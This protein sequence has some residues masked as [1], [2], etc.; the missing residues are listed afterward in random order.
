MT[1]SSDVRDHI[2]VSSV[3][4]ADQLDQIEASIRRY[5][6]L[7]HPD[8]AMLVAVWIA[9]TYTFECFDYC[10]YLHIQSDTWGCGKT[11]LL[12][13][14]RHHAKAQPP[15][16]TAPTA[17]VVFRTQRDVQV[18][19]LDEAERLR[20]HDKDN[21]GTLLQVLNAGVEKDG[22]VTR[23]TKNRIGG[24]D[25]TDFPLFGP[26][27]FAGLDD[28]AAALASRCFHVQMQAAAVRPERFRSRNVEQEARVIRDRLEQWATDQE[29]AL[30][31]V[32]D[33]MV[34]HRTSIPELTSYDDRLQ[35]LAEPLVVLASVADAERHEGTPIKPRLLE[36]IKVA[37]AHRS[38]TGKGQDIATFVQLA[39]RL[40]GNQD[41]V[42]VS[43]GELLAQCQDFMGLADLR[44][45]Q[46][47]AI[48]LKPFGLT[49]R[50]NGEFRGYEIRRQWVDQLSTRYSARNGGPH[51]QPDTADGSTGGIPGNAENL[52]P[53]GST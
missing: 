38:P 28:L 17:A 31:A 12:K 30:Q 40:L 11:T 48:F 21:F 3:R 35:D 39:R 26:K 29:G 41:T 7:S 44:N 50:S 42:F 45:P 13:V 23:L 5:V 15:I 4:L 34:K 2:A 18:L 46:S 51:G 52:Q 1:A 43:T 9:N 24:Y 32:Y 22:Q 10:G 16:L 37:A 27:A 19:L 6:E 33:E 47:L 14:I 36:G 49:P 25:P 53:V 8:L 20:D